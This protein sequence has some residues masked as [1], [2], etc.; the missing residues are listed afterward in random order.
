MKP[1]ESL[2]RRFGRYAVPNLTLLLVLGQ[3]FMYL[4]AM[5]PGGQGLIERLQLVPA[6]VLEGEVWRLL[7][8][9]VVPPL[10]SPLF[11]AI[12]LLA[13]YYFG[14]TVESLWGAFRYNVYLALGFLLTAAAGFIEPEWPASGAYVQTSVFLAFAALLPDAVI[15]IYFILPVKARYLAAF[16]WALYALQ[17][18][19]G[20][21]STR[22]TIAAA[23]TN[24][25]L[26]FGPQAFST[27]KQAKRKRDFRRK[28]D[29]AAS[30]I[31]H[32]CRV[33][34]LTSDM[35][36]RTRFRY[37]SQCAGQCCYCP[38]HLDKHEHVQAVGR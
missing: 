9:P 23:V 37:C 5:G 14:S 21:W 18:V 2:E 26:F 35:A 29:A 16:T 17:A 1:L 19:A 4:A 7:A 33:C 28:V 38:D 25:L 12:Y 30:A 36:P 3:A 13:F 31:R 34:G 22:L 20:G 24:F 15:R 27:F 10:L 6:R 11:F 32:E 8:F